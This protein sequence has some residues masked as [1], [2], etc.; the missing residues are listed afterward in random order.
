MP[1]PSAAQAAID[2]GGNIFAGR[3]VHVFTR[4]AEAEEDASRVSLEGPELDE[5]A[6]EVTEADIRVQLAAYARRQ[7]QEGKH[8]MTRQMREAENARKAASYGPVPIRVEFP[9]NF[10]LQASF[11]AAAPLAELQELVR[12]ALT[13]EAA[14]KFYLFTTPPKTEI[15]DMSV[16]FYAAGLVPA[17]RVHVGFKNW[18][19]A[20]AGES[21]LRPEVVKMMDKP[22]ARGVTM[23]KEEKKVSSEENVAGAGPPGSNQ[24]ASG[25]AQGEPKRKK[26]GG[27]PSWMKLS[28]R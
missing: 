9:N 8:L 27:M 11:A 4:E 3:P 5:S 15:K 12:A 21:F 2:K 10:V 17:A 13:P 26:S 25:S 24:G 6:Y 7:A 16:S 20:G 18:E 22:P 23:G 19:P 1:F 14:A 28:T